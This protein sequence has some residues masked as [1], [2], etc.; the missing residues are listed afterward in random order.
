[1]SKTTTTIKSEL[2]DRLDKKQAELGLDT[3]ANLVSII[4]RKGLDFLD[5]HG[6]DALLKIPNKGSKGYDPK[7]D[8]YL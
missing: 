5:A 8:R 7:K 1:M 4:L 2:I 6:Y 3:R